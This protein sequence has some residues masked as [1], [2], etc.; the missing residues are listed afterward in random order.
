MEI[1]EDS[2]QG[3]TLRGFIATLSK[4]P[5][6][7]TLRVRGVV[8]G[9]MVGVLIDGWKPTTSLMQHGCLSGV[10]RQINLRD[11]P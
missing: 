10:F 11:S 2:L 5:K 1:E 8:Q 4:V 9:Y 7:H 3:E 6:F